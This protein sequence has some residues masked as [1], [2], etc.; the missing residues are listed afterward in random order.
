MRPSGL[1]RLMV[2]ATR[3]AREARALPPERLSALEE[4]GGPILARCGS[5]LAREVP[6]EVGLVVEADF[7]GDPRHRLAFQEV[8]ARRL[9]PMPDQVSVR[10]DPE[11]AGERLDEVRR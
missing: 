8:P 4:R 10:G 11:P 7:G 5:Y 1:E 3:I 6:S 2:G 9:D